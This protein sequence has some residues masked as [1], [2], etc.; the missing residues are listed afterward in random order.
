MRRLLTY[1]IGVVLFFALISTP[2]TP[3]AQ[4][5][6]KAEPK[7]LQEKCDD[8]N[9]RNNRQ[10]EQCIAIHGLDHIPCFDQFNDGVVHCFRNFCEQ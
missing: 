8:C 4:R 2:F 9:L 3:T 1:S 7:T 5:T 10:L 6:V